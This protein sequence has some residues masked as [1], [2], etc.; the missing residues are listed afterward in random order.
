MK[1][2][3]YE[4]NQFLTDM[5]NGETVCTYFNEDE[6]K[7]NYFHDEIYEYRQKFE[8]RIGKWLMRNKPGEYIVLSGYCVCVMTI[9]EAIKRNLY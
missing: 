7:D 9:E 2:L 4:F 1:D 3:E 6:Y 8:D 5:K